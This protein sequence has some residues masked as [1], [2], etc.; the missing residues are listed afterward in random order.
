MLLLSASFAI[1]HYAKTKKKHE[2]ALETV[3]AD[4][5]LRSKKIK[6]SLA[7]QLKLIYKVSTMNRNKVISDETDYEKVK[8]YLYGAK[9]ATV[10]DAVRQCVAE[11]YPSLYVQMAEAYPM[12]SE[13]ELKICLLS[14]SARMRLPT[15][16]N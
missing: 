15:L 12:L 2:L 8:R 1:W 11:T 13:V 16:P 3:Q 9:N 6:E 14:V 10:W 7:E 4:S 5:A